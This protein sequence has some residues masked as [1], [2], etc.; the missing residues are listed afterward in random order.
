MP[1]SPPATF[2][3]GK[4]QIE[5]AR[6]GGRTCLGS[7]RKGFI[8]AIG[9]AH[10]AVTENHGVGGSIPPLGTKTATNFKHFIVW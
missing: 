4:R 1:K 8:P 2:A 6:E 3:G 5:F 10:G 7:R 9:H